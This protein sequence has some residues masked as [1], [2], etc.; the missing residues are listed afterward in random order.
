V[1]Y[2]HHVTQR[3][4]RGDFIF[5]DAD[6]YLNLKTAVRNWNNGVMVCFIK[7]FCNR[8]AVD[9]IAW[10]ASGAAGQGRLL[11]SSKKTERK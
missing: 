7:I 4:N 6:D 8:G 1:G 9:V 11:N 3:S 10:R 2:P 5:E